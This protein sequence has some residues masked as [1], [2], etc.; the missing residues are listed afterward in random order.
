LIIFCF[1]SSA[2]Y[3]INDVKDIEADRAH[4]RKKNRPIA[5]GQLPVRAAI[6]AAV[7]IT[8][9]SLAASIALS[10]LFRDGGCSLPDHQR[11]FSFWLKHVPLID[12]LLISAGF[13]LRVSAG[14]TLIVVERFSPWLFAVTTLFTLLHGLWQA[15]RGTGHPHQRP[16]AKPQAC[17]GRLHNPLL[18]QLITIVSSTTIMAYSLYTFSAVNLPENHTMMLT[19]PFVIY[20]IF[21]YLYLI[22]VKGAGGAPEDMVLSDV[23]CKSLLRSIAWRFC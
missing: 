23:R 18:D 8:V 5:S 13:V 7:I 3:L 14:V 22:Q 20:G 21:R 15:P 19:I 2:V 4:P 10:P 6:I 11:A 9:L 1:I 12:V 17:I 16:G